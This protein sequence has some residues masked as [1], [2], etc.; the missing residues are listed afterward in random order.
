MGQANQCWWRICREINVLSRFEYHTFYFLCPL[1]TYLLT[2]S[3]TMLTSARL[4]AVEWL[5]D[6]RMI[7]WKEDA[8]S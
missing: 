7:N 3:R 6:W 1:V 4:Y 5:D 8:A 2:L